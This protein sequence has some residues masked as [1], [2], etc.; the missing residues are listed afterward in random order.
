[1][2]LSQYLYV[3][4]WDETDFASQFSFEPIRINLL[5]NT[6]NVTFVERQLADV[7]T[8]INIQFRH[9]SYKQS[10]CSL[11]A[12]PSHVLPSLCQNRTC[13]DC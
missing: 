9:V 12:F 11:Q 8:T 3:A 1:M 10:E 4:A 13:F 6:D 5:D 7:Q 2:L